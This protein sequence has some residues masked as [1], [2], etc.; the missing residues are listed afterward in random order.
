[1]I[2]VLRADGSIRRKLGWWRLAEGRLRITG[3]RLDAPAAA[4]R[5]DV[6]DGYGSSGF[7]TS[8]VLFPTEGCWQVE[9]QVEGQVG[10]TTLTFVTL[11][12]SGR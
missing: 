10:A 7:Q 2:A 6:P 12:V 8:G 3:R 1:M 4:S 9:G 11:V 5:A